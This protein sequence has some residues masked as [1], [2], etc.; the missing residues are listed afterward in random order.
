MFTSQGANQIISLQEGTYR[1]FCLHNSLRKKKRYFFLLLEV[2]FSAEFSRQSLKVYNLWFSILRALSFQ[3]RVSLRQLLY[4]SHGPEV[5]KSRN[6]EIDA[7]AR[8]WCR[9]TLVWV[10][11]VCMYCCEG[12]VIYEYLLRCC[13]RVEGV[14]KEEIQILEL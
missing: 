6:W 9:S 2:V 8:G 3:R 11:R 4:H 13:D 5:N 1:S 10:C 7:L 14:G 12:W